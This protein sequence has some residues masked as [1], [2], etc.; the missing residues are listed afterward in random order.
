MWYKHG[1]SRASMVTGVKGSVARRSRKLT[2][3]PLIAA[4][5]FMVA[6]GPYGLEDL[7]GKAGYR[8]A[9][10]ILLITPVLWSIPTALMVSE[11]AAALPCEG[12]FYVWVR[13][14]MGPFWGFQESWLTLTGSVFEMAL[15]P[16]LFVAYLGQVRA[17]IL[18]GLP[19]D[20]AGTGANRALRRLEHPGRKGGG[21]RLDLAERITF[22]ALC[23]DD[24]DRAGEEIHRQRVRGIVPWLGS[25]GR[26]HYRHVEL[27]GLGQSVHDCR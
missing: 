1:V 8:A 17:A 11:L 15:Y 9:I 25:G 20:C 4:T 21:R 22:F 2:L 23:G 6:G 10:I 3:L 18:D 7:I 27:H 5:Y 14:G 13:R 19:G 16:T 24:R 26:D 12:G